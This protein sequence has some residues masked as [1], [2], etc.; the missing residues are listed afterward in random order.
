MRPTTTTS[1][2]TTT[3]TVTNQQLQ[4][5]AHNAFL[6]FRRAQQRRIDKLQQELD[7]RQQ[8]DD[9]RISGLDVHTS[10]FRVS[11]QDEGAEIFAREANEWE[12]LQVG[13][14]R[15]YR[16]SVT[17]KGL[18]KTIARAE[19]KFSDKFNRRLRTDGWMQYEVQVKLDDE[20]V[21]LSPKVWAADTQQTLEHL[22]CKSPSCHYIQRDK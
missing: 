19:K 20:W 7:L 6:L 5:G 10:R 9:N 13:T 15:K 12:G 14:Y 16:V 3:G 21:K 2:H 1:E 8:L 11:L 22:L 17:G 18:A 4:T